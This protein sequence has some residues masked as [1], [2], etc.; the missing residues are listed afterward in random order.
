M[1][2]RMF[3]KI[4]KHRESEGQ[5]CHITARRFPL[6]GA[7]Y[8]VRISRNGEELSH[9]GDFR[10]VEVLMLKDGTPREFYDLLFEAGTRVKDQKNVE[11]RLT[12]GQKKCLCSLALWKQ[13]LGV[14]GAMTGLGE[15]GAREALFQLRKMGYV[16]L[17]QRGN[18]IRFSLTNKGELANELFSCDE[19]YQSMQNQMIKSAGGL[20]WAKL[21]GRAGTQV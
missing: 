19:G 13:S 11:F 4:H 21:S 9:E 18:E 15:H 3:G 10:A 14:V 6:L 16:T 8:E 17:F 2:M 1:L 12:S 20:D 7:R 5:E